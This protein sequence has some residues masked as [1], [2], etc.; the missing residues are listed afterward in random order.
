MAP[1]GDSSNADS[2]LHQDCSSTSHSLDVKCIRV[3]E[4]E[5]LV[6]LPVDDE[7]PIVMVPPEEEETMHSLGPAPPMVCSSPFLFS[8]KCRRFF[9]PFL[10]LDRFVG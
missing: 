8:K 5:V 6:P 1:S 3:A 7:G 2:C 9:S 10:F 4:E